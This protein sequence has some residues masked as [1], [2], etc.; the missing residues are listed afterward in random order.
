MALANSCQSMLTNIYKS[1]PS[2]TI[3]SG[4]RIIH[5][6]FLSYWYDILNPLYLH[7]RNII[8]FKLQTN[9]LHLL[10]TGP[11]DPKH[12]L[13]STE[14]VSSAFLLENRNLVGK[15]LNR[16]LPSFGRACWHPLITEPAK[17]AITAS[18]TSCQH[19]FLV[20]DGY[21]HSWHLDFR[22][23]T[24]LLVPWEN[25]Y[26]TLASRAGS[27]TIRQFALHYSINAN[28]DIHRAGLKSLS[29]VVP[30]T[31]G[32]IH[33]NLHKFYLLVCQLKAPKG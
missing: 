19:P 23:F 14:L 31:Q 32:I 18:C 10:A 30:Q 17:G 3:V 33:Q 6:S 1:F 25:K 20:C 15:H 22:T 27:Q 12:R 8:E 24:F 16:R 26:N 11:R 21:S 28:S 29:S 7:E 4:P 5:F 13:K 9:C 2:P